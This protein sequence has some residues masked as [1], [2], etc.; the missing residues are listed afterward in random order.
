VGQ[1]LYTVVSKIVLPLEF[2]FY[3]FKIYIS[4]KSSQTK[5][6]LEMHAQLCSF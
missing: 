3:F 6:V 4:L 2:E 5:I 1:N